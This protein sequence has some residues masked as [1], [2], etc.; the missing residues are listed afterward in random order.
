MKLHRFYIFFG[1][2]AY[3]ST[4]TVSAVEEIINDSI[5]YDLDEITVEASKM[6]RKADMDIYHP[7]LSAVEN[8]SN[9][10]QLISR[11]MIPGIAVDEVMGKVSVAGT[12]VEIRINGRVA[13]VEQLKNLSPETVKRIEWVDNPGLRYNGANYV[14][15]V[16][17]SNPD[18][19]GSLYL[20]A[21]P[22]LNAVFGNYNANLKLNRKYSQWEI[23]AFYKPC[24]TSKVHRDYQEIF[25]FPDGFTLSRIETPISGKVKNSQNWVSLS[26]SYIKPDTTVFYASLDSWNELDDIFRTD[27]RLSLSDNSA[28]INLLNKTGNKGYTPKLSLYLEQHLP[29]QQL[30]V[31]DFTAALFTGHSF[32][33]Y[34]ESYF[35][36]S[37][38]ITDIHTYIK[39]FN[40]TYSIEADYIKN[41]NNSK[42]TAG[43]QYTAGRNRS[44]YRNLDNEVF[45]Q[46]QD[47]VYFFA[48]GFHRLGKISLAAGLGAQYTTF[49]FIETGQGSSS[50]NLRPQATLTYAP[51]QNNQLRLNFTTWQTTPT[52]NETNIA[53]QQIDGFQWNIGNPD[54]KTYN[55]YV[56]N[57]RYSFNFWRVAANFNVEAASSPKS[58][59][60]FLYWDNDRLITTYENSKGRQSLRFSLSPQIEVVKDWLSLS[61]S[62]IFLNQRTQ[63][64]GYKLYNHNWS[65]NC[66]VILSHWN[67]SLMLQYGKAPRSLSGEKLSWGED[68]SILAA[69]YDWEKWQFGVVIFQ[70]FGKYDQGSKMLSK[71]NTNEYHLRMDLRM[72]GLICSYNLQWGRQKRGVNKLIDNEVNV[73][74]SSAK[75]R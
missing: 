66:N 63:G 19:G 14:L 24:V 13:S 31:A 18:T 32:T 10:L 27:G 42:L 28:D 7:S 6:V 38:Y 73:E 69:T 16:I 39:D 60:P 41:W 12:S 2:L 21:Q 51:N 8:S 26:Y 37:D 45:H 62:L 44:K 72:V 59:A 46:H 49:K 47:K 43:L 20:S 1:I 52:L 48:E 71:W 34:L 70:P 75:S 61:G 5:A 65:G 3:A 40:Q 55:T 33:D 23:A 67:V 56:L 11:V 57:L 35:N 22:M 50:W 64:S 68:F 30:I 58:I 25:T 29:K 74:K 9:G 54:L 53:P 36:S 15:N 17:V 4:L